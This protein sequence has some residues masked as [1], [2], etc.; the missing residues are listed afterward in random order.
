M[1]WTYIIL[2]CPALLAAENVRVD[3][4]KD[5]DVISTILTE[6]NS[7]KF[8]NARLQQQ[9]TTNQKLFEERLYRQDEV[10]ANLLKEVNQSKFF[11]IPYLHCKSVTVTGEMCLTDQNNHKLWNSCFLKV[12]YLTS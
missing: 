3:A 11:E 7:L 8:E 12:P 2:L 4:V 6:L 10:I 1:C 5:N 9:M